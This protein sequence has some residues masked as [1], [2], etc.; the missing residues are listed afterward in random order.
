VDFVDVGSMTGHPA[1][2]ALLLTIKASLL[3]SRFH[4][5]PLIEGGS[6]SDD[7]TNR[8]M[9]LDEIAEMQYLEAV[10]SLRCS[11]IPP[12]VRV[13]NGQCPD[14]RDTPRRIDSVVYTSGRVSSMI[15]ESLQ[16]LVR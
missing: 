5:Q 6:V 12:G 10:R 3:W 2:D 7:D 8:S 15:Y 16:N 14:S 4:K 11:E 9:D 13:K 1:P